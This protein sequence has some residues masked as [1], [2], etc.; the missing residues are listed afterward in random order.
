VSTTIRGRLNGST[1][2]GRSGRRRSSPQRSRLR[3]LH[4]RAVP[5]DGEPRL[6]SAAE[7]LGGLGDRDLGAVDG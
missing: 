5:L 7:R 3:P 4:A 2:S 1:W 6:A